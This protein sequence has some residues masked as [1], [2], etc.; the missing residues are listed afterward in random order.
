MPSLNC[1]PAKKDVKAGIDFIKGKKIHLC[2][3][4]VNGI[5]EYNNYKYK[6]DKNGNVFEEPVKAFDDFLDCL[7][8]G[9]YTASVEFGLTGNTIIDES[10]SEDVGY[11]YDP[12]SPYSEY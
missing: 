11:G 6:E 1:N 4:A 8:Y 2:S 7:R 3:K 5:R 10:Y 12:I 9:I